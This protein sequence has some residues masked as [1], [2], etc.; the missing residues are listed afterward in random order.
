MACRYAIWGTDGPK[1]EIAPTG[2]R[3]VTTPLRCAR[4]VRRELP[5]WIE[6]GLCTDGFIVGSTDAIVLRVACCYSYIN[7][8]GIL[9]NH[10]PECKSHKREKLE[11]LHLMTIIRSCEKL[12]Q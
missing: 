4:V 11:E 12:I 5:I 7:V 8:D 6:D 3:Q 9:W 10:R 1:E 2:D